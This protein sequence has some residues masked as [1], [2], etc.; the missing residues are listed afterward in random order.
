MAYGDVTQ[1]EQAALIP[2]IW[3]IRAQQQQAERERQWALEDRQTQWAESE[4][5]RQQAFQNEQAVRQAAA[6]ERKEIAD[7][8]LRADAQEQQA[9]ERAAQAK[10]TE[11]RGKE[12]RGRKEERRKEEQAGRVKMLDT[13]AAEW[14][15]SAPEFREG[16]TAKVRGWIKDKP[17]EEQSVS[18]LRR[19]MN[20][21]LPAFRKR[22]GARLEAKEQ[23]A[24]KRAKGLENLKQEGREILRESINASMERRGEIK[25]EARKI[26]DKLKLEQ[27]AIL[28]REANNL[29][30]VIAAQGGRIDMMKVRQYIAKLAQDKGNTIWGWAIDAA[31]DED[32]KTYTGEL[33]RYVVLKEQE[34]SKFVLGDGGLPA[35]APDPAM[36]KWAHANPNDPDAQEFLRKHGE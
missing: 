8:G 32:R 33:D 23:A 9:R 20:L 11:A 2:Q 10:V 30:A 15:E 25:A 34:I 36:L 7:I 13:F 27:Q 29:K 1:R 31:G 19:A 6:R 5:R 12:E 24:H 21:A 26:I 17:L 28:A 14:H 35:A 18:S 4:R 16:I 3:A 22:A